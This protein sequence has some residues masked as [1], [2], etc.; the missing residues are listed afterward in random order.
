MRWFVFRASPPEAGLA[1]PVEPAEHEVAV[2]VREGDINGFLSK[3]WGLRDWIFIYVVPLSFLGMVGM[4]W[5]MLQQLMTPLRQMQENITAFSS[6]NLDQPASLVTPYREFRGVVA[7]FDDLRGRLHASFMQSQRFAADAS[8]E[9]RTPLTILRGHVE[10]A[11]DELPAG[12]STQVHLRV[13]EDEISRLVDVTDK[14]LLL[15]RVDADAVRLTLEPVDLSELMEEIVADAEAFQSDLT[16]SA[17]IAPHIVWRCDR[18]L[19]RQLVYNL[20]TN[21]VNY[22]EPD[23]W[24]HFR[25]L[26]LPGGLE[27]TVENPSQGF[28]PDI[29]ARAFE[30]F[31]RGNASRTRKIDGQGLGLSLCREIAHLHGGQLTLTASRVGT[32]AEPS[33]VCAMLRAPLTPLA[34][35]A[36]LRA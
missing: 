17:D 9:L 25:L 30:R 20:L 27:L 36:S 24:V 35:P 6:S 16:I 3:V 2:L 14:L 22:N 5:V 4:T 8:H 29:Q 18:Q 13:I 11:I 1:E 15:S 12:S 32:G 31:Y 26:A 7:A 21:A 19:V 28:T 33:V 23:G 10:Q 34:L